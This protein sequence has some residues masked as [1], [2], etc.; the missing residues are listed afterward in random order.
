[1]RSM[2]IVFQTRLEHNVNPD[3]IVISEVKPQNHR[4]LMTEGDFKLDGYDT[5]KCNIEHKVGRGMIIYTFQITSASEF[6]M[7]AVRD[8]YLH[9]HVTVPTIFRVGRSSKRH[10]LQAVELSQWTQ[11]AVQIVSN[12]PQQWGPPIYRFFGHAGHADPLDGWRSCS[13]KRVMSR[14]IQVRQL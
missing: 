12:R 7:E 6:S 2:L 9:Q 3:I 14:P 5:F 11:A 1:M 4:Y 8:A 10:S 13:Q